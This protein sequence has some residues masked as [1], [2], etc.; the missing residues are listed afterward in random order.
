M[1]LLLRL[2]P[3]TR[4]VSDLLDQ[5]PGVAGSHQRPAQQIVA[6]RI[7]IRMVVAMIVEPLD[8]TQVV[9]YGGVETGVD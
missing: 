4:C 7:V 1:R 8:V 3:R 5:S 6:S 2:R 9:V